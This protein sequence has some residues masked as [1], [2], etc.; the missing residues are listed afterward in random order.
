MFIFSLAW[1][2]AGYIFAW[3]SGLWSEAPRAVL[4]ALIAP[5]SAAALHLIAY[6][7][8]SRERPWARRYFPHTGKS[9]VETHPRLVFFAMAIGW[10]L[11]VF[12]LYMILRH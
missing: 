6:W 9:V 11:T 2:L 12:I 8:W 1:A 3:V 4:W 10:T 5:L 7:G